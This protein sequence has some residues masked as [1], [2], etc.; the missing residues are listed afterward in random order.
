MYN[1]AITFLFLHISVNV[2]GRQD[3]D[4]TVHEITFPPSSMNAEQTVFIQYHDDEINEPLEVFFV[5]VRADN[6]TLDPSDS[7]EYIRNGIAL[8]VIDDNDRELVFMHSNLCVC[9]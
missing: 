2:N 8:A 7:V 3:F 4:N 1:T 9:K 6:D 5:V